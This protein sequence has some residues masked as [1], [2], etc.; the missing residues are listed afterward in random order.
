MGIQPDCLCIKAPTLS[1]VR[2]SLSLH[3]D[4]RAYMEDQLG[5]FQG[6]R[7]VQEF[8]V[9]LRDLP[10]DP[11]SIRLMFTE[12]DAA[13]PELCRNCAGTVLENPTKQIET[14]QERNSKN[15]TIIGSYLFARVAVMFDFA[16][17]TDVRGTV[18]GGESLFLGL[19][20]ASEFKLASRRR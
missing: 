13:V 6:L 2:L 8:Q 15:R 9:N 1:S 11:V 3:G 4:P 18:P 14:N 12:I 20:S 19:N 10:L 16:L 5:M 7:K 17:E